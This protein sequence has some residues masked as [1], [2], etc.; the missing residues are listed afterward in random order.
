MIAFAEGTAL[1]IANTAACFALALV[2]E[3]LPA[4]GRRPLLR[5]GLGTGLAGALSTTSALAVHS[6]LEGSYPYPLATLAAGILAAVAGSAVGR[7]AE[8]RS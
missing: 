4:A 7:A 5:L 1:V 2:Y 3:V 8:V 6:V